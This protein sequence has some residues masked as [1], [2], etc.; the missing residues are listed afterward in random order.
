MTWMSAPW[1]LALDRLIDTPI[2]CAI[3]LLAG[4]V[5]VL[6]AGYAPWP[7]SWHAHLRLRLG[8]P[9]DMVARYTDQALLGAPRPFRAAAEHPPGPL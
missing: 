1:A 7:S 2:G 4:Y 6:L 3:V 9:L 8:T 5:I